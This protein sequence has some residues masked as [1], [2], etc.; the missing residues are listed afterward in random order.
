MTPQ[1]FLGEWIN[2]QQSM[3]DIFQNSFNLNPQ[4]EQKEQAGEKPSESGSPFT[5]GMQPGKD[6]TQQ[7]MDTSRQFFDHSVQTITQAYPGQ[8]ELIDKMLGSAS[9]YQHLN[10]FWEDMKKTIIGAHSDADG[11]YRKWR[12]DYLKLLGCNV[13][14]LWPEPMQNILEQSFDVGERA[15]DSLD[16][17]YQPWLE[18]ARDL[19]TLLNKS[20]AGDQ[21][22]YIDFN[23]QWQENFSA[24]FGK[25]LNVP[26]FSLNRDLMHRQLHSLDSLINYINTMNQFAAAMIKVNQETLQKVITE[27]QQM[28][29]S[30]NS[31]RTY[32]EFY[33]YWWKTN[34]EAYLK[35]FATTE[36]SEVLS[37]V[38]DA[39][40]TYKKELDQVMEKQLEFLPYPKKTDMDSVYKTLDSMKREIRFLKKEIS[41]LKEGKAIP[42]TAKGN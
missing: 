5:D 34:E 31:P 14:P 11:F 38:L 16:K 21:Q 7:W 3:L 30:G 19:Q 18:S 17:L 36:F 33:D 35:L 8:K 37:Q 20:M 40:V 23:R 41:A 28:L 1:H 15:A 22:A 29:V 4:P 25:I 13:L 39:G 12:K 10:T 24:S 26:Q 9:L 27:Y 42:D 6:W 32:K 2:L